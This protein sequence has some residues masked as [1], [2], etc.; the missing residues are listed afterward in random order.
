MIKY[1][2][3]KRVL[4]PALL[5]VIG[6]LEGVRTV[7][8]FFSGTSR[9]SHALKRAGYRVIANDYMTYAHTLA[10]C[11]VQVDREDV[12]DEAQSL[13]DEFNSLK[14][15]P[16]YVTETF[17]EKSR[18]FQPHNGARIDA[19]REAI[20]RMGLKRDL[21][22][23]CLVS[24]MEA[25]DRV[26]ST[27]GV[28][29][30][31][32]KRW[33]PRAHNDLELRLPDVLPGNG[34]DCQAHQLEARQAAKALTGDVAYVDPP[35]NQHSYLGNYH[36]WESLVRWDKPPVYG[37]A[38]KRVDCRERKSDFN[39][40]PRAAEA[41]ASFLSQVDC[42]HLVV[43]FNNEGYIKR[44][45]METL[46][47]T[48]GQVRIMERDHKRFVG[49]QIGIFNPAGERVGEVSHV[50]NT[51]YIYVVSPAR[52]GSCRARALPSGAGA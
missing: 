45:E 17:C 29:M 35:Y 4:I 37:V 30:A 12:R 52:R 44:E 42:R 10:T 32:L 9:V 34:T 40:K 11:Y 23:V 22:A 49:A 15:E 2:G 7:V 13:I 47:A 50:R 19:I 24:L 14:G 3:S 27:T 31:Y 48:R 21:K 46:L 8:D 43:S 33:A 18:Y 38:C 16:G 6:S 25:A 20:E 39:S 5:E 1:I 28:Q 36:I 41:L 51:E 26:D